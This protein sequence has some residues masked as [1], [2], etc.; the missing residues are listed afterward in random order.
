[1]PMDNVYVRAITAQKTGAGDG[2]VS[3]EVR[4]LWQTDGV[5][6]FF[7]G[8]VPR[9]TKIAPS[10]AIVIASYELLKSLM[11]SSELNVQ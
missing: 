4:K 7:R 9:V 2:Q 11:S 3:C 10:C 5:A 6:G 1:M 8:V